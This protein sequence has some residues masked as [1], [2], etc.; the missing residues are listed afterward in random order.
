[1]VVASRFA[2]TIAASG[3]AAVNAF[4][5]TFGLPRQ[6]SPM[7]ISWRT[8]QVYS[9]FPEGRAPES[10]SISFIPIH[11]DAFPP[12]PSPP[13]PHTVHV[14][15]KPNGEDAEEQGY[16]I[17]SLPFPEGANFFAEVHIPGVKGVLSRR[18]IS[19]VFS[20]EANPTGDNSCLG[21]HQA[22]LPL[23][24]EIRQA[25]GFT[26]RQVE[27]VGPSFIDA[28][29]PVSDVSIDVP[30]A[31]EPVTTTPE[32]QVDSGANDPTTE[33]P[34]N[35][36]TP[37]PSTADVPLIKELGFSTIPLDSATQGNTDPNQ[38]PSSVAPAENA[39]TDP[40]T[41]PD[42]VDDSTDTSSNNTIIDSGESSSSEDSY[43][44][45][46]D[47]SLEG[48]HSEDSYSEDSYSE[49]TSKDDPY[50]EDSYS[51]D[52]YSDNKVEMSDEVRSSYIIR[53]V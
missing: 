11:A 46:E 17:D 14:P 22:S 45:K 21:L 30:A 16:T 6:C 20:V 52:E 42:A 8:S 40:S 4:S 19:K 3:I 49:D 35:A 51:E 9:L 48:S 13:S 39:V 28:N 31:D 50:S 2:F 10:M 12:T 44:D 25:L 15:C 38:D 27:V 53:E 32:T 43:S 23:M 1:M 26:K 5:P 18:R 34:I 7:S 33:T 29:V 37:P 36:S 47:S 41:N 24:G